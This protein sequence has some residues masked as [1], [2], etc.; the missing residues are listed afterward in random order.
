LSRLLSLF[1]QASLPGHQLCP[2]TMHHEIAYGLRANTMPDMYRLF[3]PYT[4]YF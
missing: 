2:P 3:S 1:T 4:F